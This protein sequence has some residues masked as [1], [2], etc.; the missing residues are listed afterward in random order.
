MIKDIISNCKLSCKNG[1]IGNG[2]GLN[3][4]QSVLNILYW[5]KDEGYDLGSGELPKNSSELM[6]L[7]IKTRTNDIES[8]NN[9]PLDFYH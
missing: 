8:Q 6:S 3:T 7:L 1:R 9:K 2:V 4:P 5:L